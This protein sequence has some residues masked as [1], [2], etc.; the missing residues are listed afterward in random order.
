MRKYSV[1]FG[2]GP[3]EKAAMT[4][5]AI[6]PTLVP[7]L[8]E[9]ILPLRYMDNARLLHRRRS[10]E[11][12]QAAVSNWPMQKSIPIPSRQALFLYRVSY[13]GV[14]W[15]PL[16]ESRSQNLCCATCSAWLC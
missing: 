14:G 3:G 16:Y 7:H 12:P 9:A 8:I 4:S 11:K 2:G 5:L 15:V 13:R 1:R 10:V 6:Y